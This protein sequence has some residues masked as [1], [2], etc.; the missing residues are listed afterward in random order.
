MDPTLGAQQIFAITDAD[1]RALDVIGWDFVGA[2]TLPGGPSF[3]VPAPGAAL[4]FAMIA[5]IAIRRRR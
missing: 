2:A 5:L 1:I 4:L 3:V